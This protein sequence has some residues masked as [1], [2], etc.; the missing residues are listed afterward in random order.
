MTDTTETVKLSE[1]SEETILSYVDANYTL[2]VSELRKQ[3]KED[4]SLI[5]QKWYVAIEA[6]WHPSAKEMIDVY[7][8]QQ[9][10]DMYEDWDERAYDCLKQ[11]HYDR[12]QAVLDEAFK[13]GHATEY[14]ELNGP[15]VII[16]KLD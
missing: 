4:N 2:T 12:L 8:D 16:D 5:N 6:R 10:Q 11:E 9:Y 1:L 15:E 14:W 13:S 3:T 7:V